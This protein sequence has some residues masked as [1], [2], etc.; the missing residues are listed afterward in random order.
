MVE[1][2]GTRASINDVDELLRSRPSFII[3]WEGK[4]PVVAL[5]WVFGRLGMS[6]VIN[7]RLFSRLS[8]NMQMMSP[9]N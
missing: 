7:R 3:V 4:K 2:I 5:D 8:G 9:P 1:S 6:D